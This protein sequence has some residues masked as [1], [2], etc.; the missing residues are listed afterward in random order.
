M[1][2]NALDRAKSRP[3]FTLFGTDFMDPGA[4][5]AQMFED[6]IITH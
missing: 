4:D 3:L 1:R 5:D 2:H 6:E